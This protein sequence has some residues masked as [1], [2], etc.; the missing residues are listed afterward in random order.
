[1]PRD[2]SPRADMLHAQR[3]A[4]YARMQALKR[5]LDARDAAVAAKKEAAPA[6]TAKRS[7]AKKRR[8]KKGRR[9]RASQNR[10]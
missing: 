9:S 6:P 10:S 1:M 7:P 8:A 3:E 2:P 4:K 5:E